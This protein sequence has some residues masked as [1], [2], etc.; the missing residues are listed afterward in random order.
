MKTLDKT[1]SP[2]PV[3]SVTRCKTEEEAVQDKLQKMNELLSKTDLSL[4]YKNIKRA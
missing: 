2:K 4:F 3:K 1:L